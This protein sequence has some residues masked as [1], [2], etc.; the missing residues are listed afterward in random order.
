MFLE[1]VL[2]NES[3]AALEA[4]VRLLLGVEV[5]VLGEIAPILSNKRGIENLINRGSFERAA[6]ASHLHW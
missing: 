1:L 6:L 2:P 3:L 4:V 5:G